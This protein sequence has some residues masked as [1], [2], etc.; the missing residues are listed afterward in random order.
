[1]NRTF[2]TALRALVTLALASALV[3]LSLA[4]VAQAGRTLRMAVEDNYPPYSYPVADGTMA[5]FNVDIARALTQ[6]MGMDCVIV[7][8]PWDDLLPRLAHGDYDAIVACMA[9]KPDRLKYADFT[10]YYLRSKTGYIGRKGESGDTSI[11]G[12]RSRILAS[13]TGT[14]QLA[15]LTATY[16]TISTIQEYPSMQEAFLAVAGGQADLCLTPLLAGLEFLKS[17]AGLKCDIIGPA[18]T[19][20]Q[21]EYSPAHIAVPKGDKVLCT[22]LNKAL[23]TIRTNGEYATISRRYFPFS[24]Y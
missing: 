6:V 23:R 17:E 16:G 7:P 3:I 21:F 4:P 10:D 2:I 15:Y 24:V 14:A 5:G 8:V 9:I 11:E 12:M 13:Q 1:M 19:S 22:K 20:E 18:L